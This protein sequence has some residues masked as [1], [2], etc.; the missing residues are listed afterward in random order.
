MGEIT[1]LGAG[2][3]GLALADRISQADSKAKITLIDRNKY[4]FCPRD[5]IANPAA[6]KRIELDDWSENRHIHFINSF[7]ERI[8]IKRKKIYFKEGEP[9]DF[10]KLIIASGLTSKKMSI[11]G[12][13]RDGF[14]YLSQLNRSEFKDNL[15]ISQEVC[16]YVLT[17]LGLKLALAIRALGKE[18]RIISPNLDFL[19]DDKNKVMDF[20]GEKG[21]KFN[22]GASIEEAVGESSIKAVKI[23]PLKVFSGQLLII[24]SGFI[25]NLDF[26]EEDIKA[27]DTF[28]TDCQ[29]VYL[30]GDVNNSK[31]GDE[32]FFLFNHDDTLRQSLIFADFLLDSKKLEFSRKD[33][34]LDNVKLNIEKLSREGELWQSGLV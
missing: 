22:L 19:G 21:V 24:D 12:E 13:H 8:N 32:K 17:W 34:S 20:L 3:S 14:F 16:L 9:I 25:P 26:F 28:F 7:V 15:R 1:I 18:V 4:N 31:I 10:N 30:L 6:D 33:V 23:L 29:E 2:V 11:K 27:H 5:L